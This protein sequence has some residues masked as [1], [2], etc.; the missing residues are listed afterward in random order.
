MDFYHM[1][2]EYYDMVFSDIRQEVDF[3]VSRLEKKEDR[4]L[5]IACGTGQYS[6][7]LL[8]KGFIH[9]DA[10]DLD[11]SMIAQ[12]EI[13][14]DKIDF[15][16]G[17][18]Q[19]LNEYYT[20]PYKLMFCTGNSI[21]HLDSPAAAGSFIADCHLLLAP[22]GRLIIQIIN[23]D[24]IYA[25]SITALP[26]IVKDNITFE[27]KYTLKDSG[28]IFTGILTVDGRKYQSSVDLLSLKH[29]ELYSLL[30][31]NGFT[32]IELYGGFDSSPYDPLTSYALVAEA[33][34]SL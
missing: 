15:R 5:D 17:D 20:G 7:A 4:I 30:K 32:D 2:S 21:S 6:M 29:K 16:T 8:D 23:Y 3:L 31:D 28:V 24:R 9:I 33:L 26:L 12:A 25:K 10:V 19:K 11:P 34:K 27:R 1:L 13:K 22:G 18:M 14:T